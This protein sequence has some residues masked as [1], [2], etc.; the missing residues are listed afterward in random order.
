MD[1]TQQLAVLSRNPHTEGRALG[2]HHTHTPHPEAPVSTHSG[3]SPRTSQGKA[4]MDIERNT[5]PFPD[6]FTR[7]DHF[8]TAP[9][10]L[11]SHLT[12]AQWPQSVS[13]TSTGSFDS[14][15]SIHSL[16]T[17]APSSEPADILSSSSCAAAIAASAAEADSTLQ[18][19]QPRAASASYLSPFSP[20]PNHFSYSRQRTHT[21]PQQGTSTVEALDAGPLNVLSDGLDVPLPPIEPASKHP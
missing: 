12:M 11:P 21:A 7:S 13:S 8:L 19:A 17:S 15:T 14:H 10:R 18:V 6:K 16:Q 4:S 3:G 9:S 20:A 1:M 2:N 5:R